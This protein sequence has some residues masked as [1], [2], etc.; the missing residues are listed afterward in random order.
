MRTPP[1]G[2]AEASI[3]AAV[4]LDRGAA[5]RQAEPRAAQR[6]AA[7]AFGAEQPL[8]E[9]RQLV[10]RDARCAVVEVQHQPLRAA[11]ALDGGADAQRAAG[12]GVGERVFEQVHEDLVQAMRIA[13]DHRLRWCAEGL[14]G[15]RIHRDAMLREAIA[16]HGQGLLQQREREDGRLRER[17]GRRIAHA[18]AQVVDQLA[19]P[20]DLP[21][22]PQGGAVVEAAHAVLHGLDLG[23][24]GGERRAQLVRHVGQPGAPRGLDRVQALGHVVEGA[25]QQGQFVRAAHLHARAEPPVRHVLRALRERVDRAEPA[26]RQL[27]RQHQRKGQADQPGQHDD[28]RL[29]REEGPVGFAV[30]PFDGRQHQVADD[31]AAAAYRQLRGRR[32]VDAGAGDPCAGCVHHA[33]PLVDRIR[34]FP[35]IGEEAGRRRRHEAPGQE[36]QLRREAV[37]KTLL[38]MRRPCVPRRQPG[39]VLVACLGLR[40]A[41]IAHLQPMPGAL[42]LAQLV[43]AAV[44]GI[45]LLQQL[46]QPVHAPD[47]D[48]RD[49]GS[50]AAL[51]GEDGEGRGEQQ[52]D[53]QQGGE[54]EEDLSA[55]R[56]AWHRRGDRRMAA[57][58]A[59]RAWLRFRQ[60]AWRMPMS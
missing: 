51:Q 32:H 38:Q 11:A 45:V 30:E 42:V 49:I 10:G 52:Q 14:D 54:R 18:A 50:Q 12:V 17:F 29:A 8:E 41:R 13:V 24:H 40:H 47:L 34:R 59:A 57:H 5:D 26:P 4:R 7:R 55:E 43:P 22:Q 3:V 58:S 25:A 44:G 39:I 23:A 31:Q 20:H 35:R 27:P 48:L 46:R 2:D 56:Q 19:Q 36:L 16:R 15:L 28:P 21:V 37:R 60:K 9:P 6:A 53:H 1:S 33:Q